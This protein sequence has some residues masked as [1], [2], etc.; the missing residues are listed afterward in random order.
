MLG[1]LRRGEGQGGR[2]RRTLAR[3]TG[4]SP[5]SS[6]PSIMLGKLGQMG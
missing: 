3:V 2:A 4:E 1:K 5:G 6:M